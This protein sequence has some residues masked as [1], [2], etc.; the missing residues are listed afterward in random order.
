ME[1]IERITNEIDTAEAAQ[2]VLIAQLFDSFDVDDMTL[3]QFEEYLQNEF[4]MLQME[5]NLPEAPI[6]VETTIPAI[7]A[8]LE[9]LVEDLRNQI[10]G[11]ADNLGD[12]LDFNQFA[13]DFVCEEAVDEIQVAID[14]GEVDL[15]DAAVNLASVIDDIFLVEGTGETR[16][17]FEAAL[18]NEY[19]VATADDTP[20]AIELPF[21]SVPEE[22]I[23]GQA[24]LAQLT[25]LLQDLADIEAFEAWLMP[26]I[27]DAAIIFLSCEAAKMDLT[28]LVAS[29][30]SRWTDGINE[31]SQILT[32]MWHT[33]ADP[34]DEP[35]LA[36]L[37]RT[38]ATYDALKDAD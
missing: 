16:M 35:F 27:D 23:A 22:C 7:P 18:R 5:G 8:G 32:D 28:D 25:T 33:D 9:P 2:D 26:R 38:R 15:T 13:F 1:E 36:F 12:V 19:A 31:K 4:T 17:A 24:K 30:F 6:E 21:D 3:E 14:A 37:S 10:A 29:E 34:V 11:D 20:A